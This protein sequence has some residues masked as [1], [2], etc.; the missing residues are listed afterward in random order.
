MGTSGIVEPMSE[1]AL[2][3]TIKVEMNVRKALGTKYLILT[4]GN[5]GE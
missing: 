1:Q 4:P 5:Y 2:I 3:D